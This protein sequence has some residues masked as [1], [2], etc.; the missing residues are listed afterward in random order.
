MDSG[1]GG[2]LVMNGTGIYG[3]LGTLNSV[4]TLTVNS[5]TLKVNGNSGTAGVAVN[6]GGTLLGI[7]AD[8]GRQWLSP[9]AARSA[10][11]SVPGQ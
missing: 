10:P 5:G 4:D 9:S 8:C 11:G 7:G 1:S 3:M 2:A 6:S